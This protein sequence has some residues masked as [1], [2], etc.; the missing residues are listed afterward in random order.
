MADGGAG[1][2][3]LRIAEPAENASQLAAAQV[4]AGAQFLAGG[5]V[6]GPLSSDDGGASKDSDEDG[7]C[8]G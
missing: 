5:A 8:L 2:E 6:V 1:R 7:Y 3:R 4:K